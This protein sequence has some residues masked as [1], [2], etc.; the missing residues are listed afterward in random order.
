MGWPPRHT[1]DEDL[2]LHVGV[3]PSAPTAGRPPTAPTTSTVWPL[4][5]TLR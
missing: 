5:V 4:L 2:V 3:E 1:T